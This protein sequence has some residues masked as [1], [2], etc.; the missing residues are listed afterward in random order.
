MSS[1]FLREQSREVHRKSRYF[2]QT[3]PSV[4]YS[5]L[6]NYE[7]LHVAND[8]AREFTSAH[9]HT[10]TFIHGVSTPPPIQVPAAVK[11]LYAHP[12]P[13]VAHVPSLSNCLLTPGEGVERRR[14]E[15]QRER[16][17]F[18]AQRQPAF[19]RDQDEVGATHCSQTL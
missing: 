2:P 8:S 10:H 6:Y 7:L 11:A 1:V 13:D 3:Y 14:R 4:R 16:R 17:E 18:V 12:L 19:T 5:L 15:E 9:T